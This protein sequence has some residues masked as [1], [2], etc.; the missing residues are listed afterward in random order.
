MQRKIRK[1][2]WEFVACGVTD[3]NDWMFTFWANSEWSCEQHTGLFVIRCVYSSVFYSLM[4][5]HLYMRHYH[6]I[7]RPE[8][9]TLE[10]R[11]R[12]GRMRFPLL[13]ECELCIHQR[14]LPN[15]LPGLI[16]RFLVLMML[17]FNQ[18]FDNRLNR[19]LENR[20]FPD[21]LKFDFDQ[22]IILKSKNWSLCLV[23]ATPCSI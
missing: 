16:H 3:D 8:W 11:L 21:F 15:A 13:R 22:S 5:M 14:Q 17:I 6:V 2:E 23:E 1:C 9:Y 12:Q 20:F 19:L 18:S 7:A 10:A 4:W